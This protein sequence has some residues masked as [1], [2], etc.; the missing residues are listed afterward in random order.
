[1]PSDSWLGS[2]PGLIIP[3]DRLAATL[4][5]S[6]PRRP[7]RAAATFAARLTFEAVER[8]YASSVALAGVSLDIAPG[9]VVC[10]LGPSGCGKT[11]LLR[12]A[13]GIEKPSGGRVLINN[14]EVAGPN[15]FV[16]PEKRNV[17]L[18]FQDFA[19]FP[20][21]SI[22]DNVAFGLKAL[23]KEDARREALAALERVG[24]ARHA[25]E[26][27]HT[28]S[29][30]E[31]QRVALARAIVPRPAVM[32]MDEPFS[33]LDVQ[34][35][36]RLQEETLRIL[37]EARA[38]SLIVTHAPSEALRLGNRIVVMRKG[39]IVQA[40]KA[41]ELYRNPADLFVA[42]LFSEINEIKMSVTGGALRTPFGSFAVPGLMDGDQAILCVRRRAIRLVEQ[43]QGIA[44][45][46]L[47]AQFL[48]DLY[49]VEIAAEGFDQPLF[50]LVREFEVPPQGADVSLTVDPGSVLV[51]PAEDAANMDGNLTRET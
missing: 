43:G 35:R 11:T 9:E 19:L 49:A 15:R 45:R 1:M 3:E 20:H 31:Q 41:E 32:L 13:S 38:T 36:D 7:I 18:M 50:T 4:R 16:P 23:P 26:F 27:P 33:G 28:L 30:G 10:L 42:R 46:V 6:Q 40:G 24:L 48:G 22:I 14:S 5:H 17:G 21:L 29:G 37:R 47:H 8:R 12:I 39:R 51:F 2:A 25:E 34:L 44:G